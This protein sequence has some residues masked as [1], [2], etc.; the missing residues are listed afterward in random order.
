MADSRLEQ[1]DSAVAARREFHQKFTEYCQMMYNRASKDWLAELAKVRGF[2][3]ELLEKLGIFYVG[4]MAE[5]L[6]P[7]YL[8]DLKD[9][10]VISQ[11]NNRPIFHE[12]WAIPIR[13]T[14]GL[15]QNL[16]GYSPN[17][18]ERY[19]YG[20]AKYYARSD[21]LWG[22]ENLPKA[23]EM[24]YAVLT[25]GITDA[26]RLRCLGIENAFGRCGTLQSEA[27]MAQLSRCRYGVIF[28]HDR[29]DAGDKTR[30]HWV[31]TRYIRLN[32]FV[33][34]KD[35]DEM[36][37]DTPENKEWFME[38]FNEAVRRLTAQEHRGVPSALEDLTIL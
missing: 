30:K 36:L 4:Q 11:S 15:V 31:T 1:M 17:F 20:T 23:Y 29:D 34:Y 5:M 38:Y 25:E 19:I 2:D 21:T 13:D 3:L 14:D 26:I 12:R 16:V 33:A 8:G 28:I 22:L 6:L 37:R 9:F 24:G 18:D 27:V 7:S 35:V 32:T 10:G